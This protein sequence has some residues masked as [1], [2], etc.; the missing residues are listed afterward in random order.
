MAI[1]MIVCAGF[2]VF[3]FIALRYGYSKAIQNIDDKINQIQKK[4][5]EASQKREL[6]LHNLYEDRNKQSQTHEYIDQ[7]FRLKHQ[8]LMDL[9]QQASEDLSNVLRMR[10]NNTD[11]VFDKIR[12]ETIETI[13]KEISDLT[14]LVLKEFSSTSLPKEQHQHLNDQAIE[15]ISVFL[16]DSHPLNKNK[17]HP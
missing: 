3:M 9:K 2:C 6:T 5:N 14:L 16:T 8:E 17:H 7:T 1:N 13:K 4:I 11:L 15:N 10:Q 12:H